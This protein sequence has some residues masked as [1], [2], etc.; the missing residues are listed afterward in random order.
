VGPGKSEPP[1]FRERSK[2]KV[3]ISFIAY[4][5]MG[6]AASKNKNTNNPFSV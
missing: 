1:R 6:Q 3:L 4:P 2:Q 5:K